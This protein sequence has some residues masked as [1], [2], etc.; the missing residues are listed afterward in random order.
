MCTNCGNNKCGGCNK[1]CIKVHKPLTWI[2]GQTGVP[3]EQGDPG[4]GIINI[5]DNGDGTITIF[6]SDGTDY[7]VVL[8]ATPAG[9]HLV[10]INPV[11]GDDN[12]WEL[13]Y[14]DASTLVIPAA[15]YLVDVSTG[16]ALIQNQAGHP[17]EIKG[18]KADGTNNKIVIGSDGTDVLHNVKQ[19]GRHNQLIFQDNAGTNNYLQPFVPRYETF[20]GSTAPVTKSGG[21]P[22][23][24]NA[25]TENFELALE[26]LDA[27]KAILYYNIVQ[28]F[29]CTYNDLSFT[30]AVERKFHG[31]FAFTLPDGTVELPTDIWDANNSFYF[32]MNHTVCTYDIYKDEA[33]DITNKLRRY[34]QHKVAD[35]YLAPAASGATDPG[36]LGDTLT[37]DKLVFR[38]PY[39]ENLTDPG[40]GSDVTVTYRFE[41]IGSILCHL[42]TDTDFLSTIASQ[43]KNH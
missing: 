29:D 2:S 1:N 24:T 39:M 3:G 28:R 16:E 33:D 15:Y 38:Y 9:K 8:P 11:P 5:V 23:I 37:G 30:N 4:T 12:E 41:A 34:A 22:V 43:I 6:L 35:A 13:E 14:D 42:D 25:F 7:T 27:Y 17:T 10:A 18:V 40:G 36:W 32:N 26:Y 19:Y 20:G 31:V 21:G